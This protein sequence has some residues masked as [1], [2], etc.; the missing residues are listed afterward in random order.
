MYAAP[1]CSAYTREI[2]KSSPHLKEFSEVYAVKAN[3]A[4]N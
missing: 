2:I 3:S 4:L 1:T